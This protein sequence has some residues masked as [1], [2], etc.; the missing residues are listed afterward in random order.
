[1]LEWLKPILGEG[2]TDEIDD[3]ISKEIGK[4]DCAKWRQRN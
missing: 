2:Y 4:A 1:M 3:K